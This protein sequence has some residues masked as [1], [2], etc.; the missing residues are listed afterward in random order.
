MANEYATWPVLADFHKNLKRELRRRKSQT[1]GE[2]NKPRAVWARVVSNAIP[3]RQGSITAKEARENRK[4]NSSSLR[5]DI[6][7]MVGGLLRES[8]ATRGG[9]EPVYQRVTKGRE[10]LDRPMPGIESISVESKGEY[11]SLR[12]ITITWF[13]PS[14]EDLDILAPYWLTPGISVLVEWGWSNA[15]QIPVMIDIYDE[16]KMVDLYQHP[17]KILNDIVLK[18]GSDGTIDADYAGN[19]DFFMGI[20]TNFTWNMNDDG[21]FG[22]TTELT[23]FGE[24]MLAMNLNK[25]VK[26][27]GGS[28]T[29]SDLAD[30]EKKKPHRL[31]NI[32]E[33]V[34]IAFNAKNLKIEKD[35]ITDEL[36]LDAKNIVKRP[37][38][39]RD[40]R[41]GGGG[42]SGGTW[43]EPQDFENDIYVTWEYIEKRI[44]NFHACIIVGPDGEYAFEIDSSQTK[45]ANDGFLYSRDIDVLINNNGNGEMIP[46][47]TPPFDY[48]K[49]KFGDTTAD[50][51]GFLKNVYIK[52]SF[53]INTF[54]TSE[55]LQEALETFMIKIRSAV[56]DLWDLKIQT[57]TLNESKSHIIDQ[58]YVSDKS[59]VDMTSLLEPEHAETDQ[60]VFNFGGYSGESILQNVSFTSKMTNEIALTYFFG[61]N[62]ADGWSN[63]SYNNDSDF[64]VQAI[65][66]STIDRVLRNLQFKTEPVILEESKEEEE[67]S[68]LSIEGG[69]LSLDKASNVLGWKSGKPPISTVWFNYKDEMDIKLVSEH[70]RRKGVENKQKNIFVYP[71]EITITIDGISGILPGNVFTMDNLPRMYRESG[72][73]QIVEISHDVS[74]EDWTT[75]LR[76]FFRPVN[77]YEGD[78]E[79]I[80]SSKY[81]KPEESDSTIDEGFIDNEPI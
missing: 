20:I 54:K 76:A 19:Q 17:I 38:D 63:T 66:G 45:V 42:I 23:T 78:A 30:G 3:V 74:P 21:T 25:D 28:A 49:L 56:F 81:V 7:I 50:K 51:D 36:K 5:P 60:G 40:D 52:R 69:V 73:F 14:V 46:F 6:N 35:F 9:F 32:R 22:C 29:T 39:T 75:D 1:F 68:G 11:G 55:T 8:G 34:D 48:D 59:L 15:G 12:K 64:G 27:T 37:I 18:A 31:Y 47:S 61:K 10:L 43:G 16:T 44:I 26:S 57:K 2:G 79:R 58:R 65:Y 53:V 77:A 70:L 80:A 13:C 72:L 62:K 71:L 67:F 24:T 41:G 33:F 4:L